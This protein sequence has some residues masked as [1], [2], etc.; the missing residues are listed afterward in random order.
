M[1][2]VGIRSIINPSKEAVWA[3]IGTAFLLALTLLLASLNIA[4][5]KQDHRARPAGGRQ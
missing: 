1:D 2:K 3:A 4:C 5:M